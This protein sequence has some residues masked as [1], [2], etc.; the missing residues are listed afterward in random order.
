LAK[1]RVLLDEDVRADVRAA[2]PSKVNVATIAELGLS[3]KHDKDVVEEGIYRK[4]LIVT[5]NKDFVPQYR[6]HDW[7]KGKD[8]RHFWG[9]IFLAHSTSLSQIEQVRLALKEI[10]Y[11]SDDILTVSNTGIVTRERIWSPK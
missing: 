1:L 10:D 5:A 11:K 7:R 6:D 8:G 2:F 3:G 9:L 4:A